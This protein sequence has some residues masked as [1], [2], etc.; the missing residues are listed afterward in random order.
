LSRYVYQLRAQTPLPQFAVFQRTDTVTTTTAVDKVKYTTN[1]QQGK[2]TPTST[3]SPQKIEVT[4][5]WALPSPAQRCPRYK[6]RQTTISDSQR[7]AGSNT[8][9]DTTQREAVSLSCCENTDARGSDC[10]MKQAENNV[11]G[12]A[13]TQLGSRLTTRGLCNFRG[14]LLFM[15]YSICRIRIWIQ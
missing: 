4:G 7:F 13:H 1:V 2:F 14:D 11:C 8:K 9:P 3:T 6:Q 15:M 12:T 10:G 5:V